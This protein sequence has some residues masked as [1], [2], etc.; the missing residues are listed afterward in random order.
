M[1]V[2]QG[3]GCVAG[4]RLYDCNG[5]YGL[6]SWHRRLGGLGFG[7]QHILEGGSICVLNSRE[8]GSV[9]LPTRFVGD[10]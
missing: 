10:V 2:E 8:G 6:R 9:V 1:G 3:G 7:L 4:Q 5:L